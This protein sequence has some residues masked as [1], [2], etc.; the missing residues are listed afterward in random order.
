MF[1][2]P[3]QG[4]IDLQGVPCKPYRVWV[5]SALAVNWVLLEWI[6][7]KD[8]TSANPEKIHFKNLA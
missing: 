2:E 3:L 7:L 8:A 1:I 5:C 6:Q 4:R